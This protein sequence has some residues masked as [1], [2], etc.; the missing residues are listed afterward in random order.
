M[1]L[2]HAEQEEKA[3]SYE[4]ARQ[5]YITKCARE[6]RAQRRRQ[7]R[8]QNFRTDLRIAI[9]FIFFIFTSVWF[10]QNIDAVVAWWSLRFSPCR[11]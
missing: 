1:P 11:I 9:Y 3:R 6:E 10:F 7:E 2:T 5:H 4:A 8:R